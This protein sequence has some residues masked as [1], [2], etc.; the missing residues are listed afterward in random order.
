MIGPL[1]LKETFLNMEDQIQKA[2]D[3]GDYVLLD[4]MAAK[5]HR[6]VVD[7]QEFSTPNDNH[8]TKGI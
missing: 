3:E 1:R 8:E 6:M 5:L 2:K 7:I 4:R